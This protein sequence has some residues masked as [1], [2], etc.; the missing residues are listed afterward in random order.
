MNNCDSEPASWNSY[1]VISLTLYLSG[2]V[3]AC[4]VCVCVG[5]RA[6]VLFCL[7]SVPDCLEGLT[8]FHTLLTTVT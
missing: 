6:G 2:V 3:P 1:E 7:T 4:L 8:Y 5:V